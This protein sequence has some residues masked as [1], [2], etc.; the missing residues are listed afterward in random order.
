MI[1]KYGSRTNI[2]T[3]INKGPVLKLPPPPPVGVAAALAL[4]CVSDTLLT[5]ANKLAVVA[6]PAPHALLAFQNGVTVLL[7]LLLTH[8]VP[9]RVGGALPLLTTAAVRTWLPLTLLFVGMLASSLL[10]LL[11]VSAVTLIVFRN[12]GT[13]VTAFFERSVLGTEI[14]PLS[15]ASLL[16]ILFGVVLYGLHDL[17]FSAVGYAWLTLNIACTAAFQIYVKGLITAHP[18]EGPDAI[19]PFGM[20]YFNNLISLP[21]FALMAVGAGE[22]IRLPAL[23]SALS[24]RAWA[25][26]MLSAVLGFAL[27]TSAFLVNKLVSATSMMVANNVNKFA[28]IVL[29][30]LF[31]HATIGPL[32][33]LGMALVMASAWLYSH[34]K[35]PWDKSGA[36]HTVFSVLG[37]RRLLYMAAGVAVA[38]F[39]YQRSKADF[40]SIQRD[41]F[42]YSSYIDY[43]RFIP[44][45]VGPRWTPQPGIRSENDTVFYM[46]ESDFLSCPLAAAEPG[47]KR[48]CDAKNGGACAAPPINLNVDYFGTLPAVTVSGESVQRAIQRTLRSAW[49]DDPPQIDF[50]VR[51]GCMGHYELQLLLPSIE[52]FWPEFLGEVIIVL[53]AGNNKTLEYFLPR[54]WRD[55][56]QS[57]RFVYENVPCL[58]GYLFN[59]VSAMNMD[60]HSHAQ[61]ITSTDSDSTLHSPVTPDILF[62]AGGALKLAFSQVFQKPAFIKET[63][64]FTGAGTCSSHTMVTLPITFARETFRAYREWQSTTECY[65]DKVVRFQ[66]DPKPEGFKTKDF[67]WMCQLSTFIQITN[68]T[69]DKYALIDLDD[70]RGP[71]LQRFALH[72][73]YECVNEIKASYEESS[74]LIWLEGICRI[75]GEA[76]VPDCANITTKHVDYATYAYAEAFS[77]ASN[78]FCAIRLSEYVDLF[79]AAEN[80]S[81]IV[82]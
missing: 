55:T 10:A 2:T 58:P 40:A 27:S 4:Y 31:V 15:V 68:I 30:E 19:G 63:E 75:L 71:V 82:R 20:S 28:L 51:V 52:L 29:S 41:E 54:N 11:Q 70:R 64:F 25:A 43:E 38:F 6:L 50:Y 72:T 56:R 34:S 73:T 21:V 42:P 44:K 33:A 13:L 45:R 80:R 57:Y 12:L 24:A 81:R 36:L 7:L 16:G 48:L 66:F 37:M 26:V 65:Y 47:F 49:G 1:K 67:C 5:L 69:L 17:Q 35:G 79:R 22:L 61:Y 9:D 18:K 3:D 77:W 53:D 60:M 74:R 32:A 78:T 59:Q 39:F 46:R 14:S 76:I 62:A 23:V 8:V